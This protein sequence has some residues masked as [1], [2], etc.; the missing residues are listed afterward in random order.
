M[1]P[2][3]PKTKRG[4]IVNAVAAAATAPAFFI[5]FLLELSAA[6][7]GLLFFIGMS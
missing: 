3:P 5:N 1:N 4:K 6:G 2:L 7:G